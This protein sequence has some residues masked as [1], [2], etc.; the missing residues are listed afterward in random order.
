MQRR[1]ALFRDSYSLQ[2]FYKQLPVVCS[3]K[4]IE[5]GKFAASTGRPTAKNLWLPDPPPGALPIDFTGGSA[6]RPP[7]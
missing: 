2:F 5:W 1:R 4:C 6:P 7:L 3:L